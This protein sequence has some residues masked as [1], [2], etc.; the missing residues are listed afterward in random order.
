[1]NCD[2]E[3]FRLFAVDDDDENDDN[4]NSKEKIYQKINFKNKFKKIFLLPSSIIINSKQK[5]IRQANQYLWSVS[6]VNESHT[7]TMRWREREN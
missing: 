5:K 7:H 1:M 3:E 2:S 4:N 6:Y